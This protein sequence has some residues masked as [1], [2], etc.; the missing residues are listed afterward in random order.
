MA[1]ILELDAQIAWKLNKTPIEFRAERYFCVL[2]PVKHHISF[3][4]FN[5]GDISDPEA[6]LHSKRRASYVRLRSPDD[7]HETPMNLVMHAHRTE[8][9]RPL[10]CLRPL[11]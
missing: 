1:F 3:W 6:R 8:G 4:I 5:N 2:W 11:M 7:A 9:V 10:Y